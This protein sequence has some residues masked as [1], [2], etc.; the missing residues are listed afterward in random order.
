MRYLIKLKSCPENPASN[1]L[2]LTNS[3][4][5]EGVR[6]SKP[7]HL[8]MASEI[9]DPSI[10][11]QQ[12][13]ETRCSEIPPWKA[14]DPLICKKSIEKKSSAL[15]IKARFMD[16][17]QA[18][19]D[20]IK[21]FTDGSKT[22]NGVGCA[23]VHGSYSYSGRISNNASVFTAEL[24]AIAKALQIIFTLRGNKFTVY[25]DSYSALLAIKMYNSSNPIVQQ[26]MLCLCRLTS[27]SKQVHF[28]WV[29]AHVGIMGNE[30]A[31]REAKS[32]IARES[33]TLNFIPHS[34]LK[35][36]IHSYIKKKW[37]NHWSSP[38]LANN[39]KYKKIRESVDHWSSGY[40]KIRKTEVVLSRLRIGHT[41]ITHQFLLE[42]GSAPECARCDEVLSVEHI[43]VRCQIYNATRRKYGLLGKSIS[44]ILGDDADIS[45]LVQFLKEINLLEK[46]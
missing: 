41:H 44:E 13:K 12:V 33:I 43:L 30:L 26:I 19:V 29:P 7:F 20:S 36:V 14:P 17:D 34:D 8:R 9:Q 25:S 37:Q 2:K 28:C 35:R 6:S 45:S 24:T 39:R 1:V 10:L 4:K 42:G 27:R 11:N 18:H 16:H 5:F 15:E 3:P 22:V 40:Q 38:E 32:V 46:I 23:V 21:L 31:D